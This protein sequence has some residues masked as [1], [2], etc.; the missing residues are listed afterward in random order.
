MLDISEEYITDDFVQ[1]HM[2]EISKAAKGDADAIDNLH[3]ELAKDIV[4]NIAINNKDLFNDIDIESLTEKIN[5]IKIPDI[6]VGASMDFTE[7]DADMQEFTKDMVEIVN[8]AHM[9]A[10][11]AKA[12][13]GQMGF[14]ANF[15]T[16]PQKVT[17]S[18]PEMTTETEIESI[19]PLKTRSTTYQ[20]GSKEVEM[21]VDVPALT[22]DGSEPKINLTRKA[23][24]SYNNYS[25]KNKGGKSAGGDNKPDKMDPLKNEIDR[26]HKVNTQITK[27][28][29]SLKKL[30]SQ[31]EKFVGGELLDNLNK[32]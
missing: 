22:T 1:E 4:L 12:F 18:V 24:G 28:D 2:E 17:N 8:S 26:Y 21:T 9:T 5:N 30:Q 7:M 15:K 27:V 19:F 25:S 16:T 11:E 29:N 31:Q 14:E 20:S 23:S 13:F 3:K 6:K 10:D 32:Q